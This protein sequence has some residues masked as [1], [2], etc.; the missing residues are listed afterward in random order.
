MQLH[1][2]NMMK[3]CIIIPLSCYLPQFL[4][5]QHLQSFR[6]FKSISYWKEKKTLPS[7]HKAKK[8]EKLHK[9]VS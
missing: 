5:S 3:N 9:N 6:S 7:E 1:R 4:V 8:S 2:D